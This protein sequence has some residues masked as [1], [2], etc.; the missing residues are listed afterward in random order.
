MCK[1]I[2]PFVKWAGGK[3]QLVE[4]IEKR[5]PSEFG[6]SINR[7]IEPFVGGGA[8]LIH[9]LSDPKY[10]NVNDIYINDVNIKLIN[11]YLAIQKSVE[12]I[13]ELLKKYQDEYNQ[14]FDTKEERNEFRKKYYYHQRDEFNKFTDEDISQAFQYGN[15]N[16]ES[17]ALFIFLNRTCFN[18]LYRVNRKGDYNVPMGSYSNPKIFDEENLKALSGLFQRVNL[19]SGPYYELSNL[20]DDHTLVYCDPPYRPLTVTASFTS[21]SKYD[22][23][24]DD[25]KALAEWAHKMYIEN[26]GYFILSNADPHNSNE[27][28]DFMDEIYSDFTI[29]RIKAKRRISRNVEGRKDIFE[30]LIHKFPE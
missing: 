30:L 9:I 29:E 24:D 10:K 23:N 2:T 6:K 16:I 18:G 3:G 12:K 14:P 5:F 4:T 13:C 1:E 21:Y 15:P 20:I 25:Q 7:Y 8:L 11:T 28:D 27:S 17:A 26:R 19:K 22:F